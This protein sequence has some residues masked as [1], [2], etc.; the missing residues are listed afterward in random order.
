MNILRIDTFDDM[1]NLFDTAL[2]IQGFNIS[3]ARRELAAVQQLELT[4]FLEHQHRAKWNIFNYHLTN[5]THYKTNL[6]HQTKAPIE[7]WNDIPVTK[8]NYF[9]TNIKSNLSK[10]HQISQVFQNSTSG[11]SGIPFAFAKS[12]Y[13]HAMT[14]AVIQDRFGRHGLSFNQSL[15]ARFYGIPFDPKSAYYKEKIKDFLGRRV[16]FPVFNL[17]DAVLAGYTTQFR[18]RPFVYLNGYTSSLVLFAQ[19]LIRQEIVL[20][21]ICP[22]LLRCVTTS[23]MCD[24]LDR[25]IMQTAF[26]VPVVNEYGAAE[27]D[28]IAFE[29]ENFDWILNEETLYIEILDENDNVVPDGNEGRIVVTS[30]YNMAMPFIRYELGDIGIIANE[31]KGIYRILQKLI[32]RTNDIATLPSGRKIPG[33]TFYYVTKSLLKKN[34]LIKELVIKQIAVD[35][36]RIEYVSTRPLEEPEK[37]EVQKLMDTYLEPNLHVTFQWKD[38]IVRQPSGKLK[39]FSIEFE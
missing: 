18:K 35:R 23:E 26:G 38:K 4:A 30:L 29:N 2:K 17:S 21:D 19:Y 34:G 33:L 3:K 8:K 36:F 31:R 27:L 32:G 20:K 39:Q 6:L 13:C 25:Q 14:W 12:K 15:Q 24:E 37:I 7:E 16:R 11:S 9:Q 5:N 28:L 10:G 1:L 22:T